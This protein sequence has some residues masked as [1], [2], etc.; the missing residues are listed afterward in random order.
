MIIVYKYIVNRFFNELSKVLS[1]RLVILYIMNTFTICC[2]AISFVYASSETLFVFGMFLIAAAFQTFIPC[3]YGD[4]LHF[5]NEK[6]AFA[7]GDCNWIEQNQQFKRDLIFF[8]QNAQ[9]PLM[10]LAG[11]FIPCSMKT[12]VNIVKLA[13]SIFVLFKE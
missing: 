3:L 6:L 2:F 11:G 9:K 13:Y 8:T 1:T 5:E 10:V 7:V 4:N 12:F